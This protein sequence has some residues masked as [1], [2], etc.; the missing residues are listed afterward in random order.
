MRTPR[1]HIP[2]AQASRRTQEGGAGV[3]NRGVDRHEI[4]DPE[5]LQAHRKL[6]LR[7]RR[8]PKAWSPAMTAVGLS[9]GCMSPR[10]TT[11]FAS[12][13]TWLRR[14]QR[15]ADRQDGKTDVRAFRLTA[16]SVDAAALSGH[17]RGGHRACNVRHWVRHR[18]DLPKVGPTWA[19]VAQ[20]LPTNL[21]NSRRRPVRLLGPHCQFFDAAQS[22]A[23]HVAFRNPNAALHR[24]RRAR[25][26]ESPR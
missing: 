17:R 23:H 4:R 1:R 8:G 25:A 13:S 2:T 6:P 20:T 16:A 3:G 10:H 9:T 12:T 19:E 26:L 7:P 14:H 5:A 15:M 21:A 11:T 18:P 22:R 24:L